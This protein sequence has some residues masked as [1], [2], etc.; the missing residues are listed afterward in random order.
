[1]QKTTKSEP[2]Q[3]LKPHFFQ[4]TLPKGELRKQRRES[5]AKRPLEYALTIPIK[6]LTVYFPQDRT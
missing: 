6:Y 2:P 3:K 5:Q 4:T 1:M